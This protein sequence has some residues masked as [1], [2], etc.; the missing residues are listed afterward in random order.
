[1]CDRQR[2]SVW[3]GCAHVSKNGGGE[4]GRGSKKRNMPGEGRDINHA[5]S[6][7]APWEFIRI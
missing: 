4:S 7:L 1:M 5:K 6:N 3:G 2:V